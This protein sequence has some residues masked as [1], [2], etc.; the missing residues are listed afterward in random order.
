M[1]KE[2]E[3]QDFPP[4]GGSGFD[5]KYVYNPQGFLQLTLQHTSHNDNSVVLLSLYGPPGKDADS[6]MPIDVN[7]FASSTKDILLV[8]D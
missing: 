8:E 2:L 5:F 3:N 1:D 6:R 4:N 7:V